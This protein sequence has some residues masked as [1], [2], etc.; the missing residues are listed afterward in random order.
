VRDD[1]RLAAEQ[2]RLIS[3]LVAGDELPRGIDP[4]GA[5]A[6]STILMGKRRKAMVNAAPEIPRALGAEFVARFAEFAP[7]VPLSE[8][9]S[10]LGDAIAFLGWLRRN[11]LLPA[12]LRYTRVWLRWRRIR[13]SVR[14]AALRARQYVPR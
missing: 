12:E 11:A 8:N 14:G 7:A 13:E 1:A 10:G 2:G 4:R 5:R 6:L 3:S 9:E